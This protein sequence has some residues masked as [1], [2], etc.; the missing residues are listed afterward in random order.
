MIAI[1]CYN[2]NDTFNLVQYTINNNITSNPHY[3]HNNFYT[4]YKF[5]AS[6]FIVIELKIIAVGV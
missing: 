1:L 3:L 5:Q 6:R 2:N 4:M